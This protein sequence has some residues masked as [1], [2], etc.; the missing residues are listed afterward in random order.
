MCVEA[1]HER[2][3]DQKKDLFAS[4]NIVIKAYC[5]AMVE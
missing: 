5:D 1:F 4:Y 2:S 3:E